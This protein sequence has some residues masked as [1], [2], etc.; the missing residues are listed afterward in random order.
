MFFAVFSYQSAQAAGPNLDPNAWVAGMA[1]APCGAGTVSPAEIP[2]E[3]EIFECEMASDPDPA[4]ADK[5][6][7]EQRLRIRE[8][9]GMKNPAT[10]WRMQASLA[11]DNTFMGLVP[12]GDDYG[13]T[14]GLGVALNKVDPEGI[15]KSFGFTSEVFTKQLGGVFKKDSNG[16]PVWTGNFEQKFREISQIQY[17]RDNMYAG[18]AYYTKVGAGIGLVNERQYIPGLALWQ[19]HQWHKLLGIYNFE[20]DP[21]GVLFPFA[22]VNGAVGVLKP[23]FQGE[24]VCKALGRGHAEAGMT[25]NSYMAGSHVY[26]LVGMEVDLFK[27]KKGKEMPGRPYNVTAYGSSKLSAY[28]NGES[29]IQSTVGVRTTVGARTSLGMDMVFQNWDR[30]IALEKYNN[31]RPHESVM[32]IHYIYYFLRKD[33]KKNPNR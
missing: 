2:A 15:R 18:Q 21:S 17:S 20:Q 33:P 29:G 25:L 23:L 14:H 26:F 10:P 27:S 7:Q 19:Q 1:S 32:N 16:D 31:D 22:Q 5:L 9:F 28:S 6:T 13:Y 24:G 11:N 30:N 8:L 4:R 3:V 12:S